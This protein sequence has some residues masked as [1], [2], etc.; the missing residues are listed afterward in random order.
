VPVG[1]A[2]HPDH[3]D[4]RDQ[5]LAEYGLIADMAAPFNLDEWEASIHDDRGDPPH[6]PETG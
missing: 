5:V 1:V 3:R 2:F 4:E 6:N